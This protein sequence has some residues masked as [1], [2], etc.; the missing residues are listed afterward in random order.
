MPN[1]LNIESEWICVRRLL[2]MN[3]HYVAH[4]LWQFNANLKCQAIHAM[5]AK[6]HRYNV[7]FRYYYWNMWNLTKI[8][9]HEENIKDPT[10]TV[11]L[12]RMEAANH[13]HVY[14]KQLS[15]WCFIRIGQISSLTPKKPTPTSTF[16]NTVMRIIEIS[17]V[18]IGLSHDL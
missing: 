7:N 16:H 4:P 13:K 10:Y 6:C 2:Y 9:A 15:I 8:W 3:E 14:G 12:N 17:I 18:F 5:R 11:D 1:K